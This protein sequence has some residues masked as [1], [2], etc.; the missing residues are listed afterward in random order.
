MHNQSIPVP[1]L[2][3]HHYLKGIWC[4]SMYSNPYTPIGSLEVDPDI[5]M[6]PGFVT[7]PLSDPEV[8]KQLESGIHL[9]LQWFTNTLYLHCPSSHIHASTP[10]YVDKKQEEEAKKW[11]THW[12]NCQ[13]K[14]A[15]GLWLCTYTRTDWQNFKGMTLRSRYYC[16]QQQVDVCWN[17]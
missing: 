5:W 8:Q 14:T 16:K 1:L 6:L 7:V 13:T 11:K 12:Y 4:T 10:R 17:T 3:G 9:F 2:R 15:R